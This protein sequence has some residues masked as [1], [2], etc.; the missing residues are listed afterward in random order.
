MSGH[1]STRF[2][3][4]ADPTPIPRATDGHDLDEPGYFLSRELTWLNFSFR[5]LHEAEDARTPLLERLK[6]LAIVGSNLDK[7]YMQGIGALKRQ[8]EAGSTERTIDGRTPA[9]QIQQCYQV[10]RSL[11][12][13][14]RETGRELL[15][16]LAAAGIRGG[17]LEGCHG[18]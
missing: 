9:E 16:A 1:L 4:P 17:R 2:R 3:T 14:Q 11:E 18:G 12:A 15:A 6:F 13:R 8:V 10:V 5:V 7:F